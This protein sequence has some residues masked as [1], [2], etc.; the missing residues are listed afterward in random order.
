MPTFAVHDDNSIFYNGVVKVAG[1][2]ID[3]IFGIATTNQPI[4]VRSVKVL[5]WDEKTYSSMQCNADIIE[6]KYSFEYVK[7]WVDTKNYIDSSTFDNKD[8]KNIQPSPMTS[9]CL[10]KC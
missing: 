10:F 7:K 6:Q 3:N 9:S 4:L 5:C 1:P 8:Y 2:P